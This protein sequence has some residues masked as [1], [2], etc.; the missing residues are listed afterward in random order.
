MSCREQ[1]AQCRLARRETPAKR[2]RLWLASRIGRILAGGL[3]TVLT[4]LS[5]LLA[6]LTGCG[7]SKGAVGKPALGPLFSK[8]GESKAEKE[9]LKKAVEK[10]PFPRARSRPVDLDA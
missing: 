10:D 2:P 9:A 8:P 4:G 7:A 6:G 1:M 3:L 5:V